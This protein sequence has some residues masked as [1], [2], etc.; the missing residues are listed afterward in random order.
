MK[1]IRKIY[2]CNNTLETNRIIKRLIHI[3][4]IKVHEKQY[5][6]NTKF[7]GNTITC[8][9]IKHPHQTFVLIQLSTA[10]SNNT[11]QTVQ[12]HNRNNDQI[13]TE[14]KHPCAR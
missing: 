6:Y 11:R 4:E 10:D 1:S 8:N 3:I 9:Q 13:H 12:H 2:W 7:I 14:R 5:N